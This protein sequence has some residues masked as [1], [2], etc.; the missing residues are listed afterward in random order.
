M[1]PVWYFT[2]YMRVEAGSTRR[3]LMAGGSMHRRL[4]SYQ[5]VNYV[6]SGTNQHVHNP[7][8]S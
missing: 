5:L 8:L 2:S 7:C 4:R 6:N 1:E 3:G